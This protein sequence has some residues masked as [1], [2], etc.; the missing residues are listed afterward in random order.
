MELSWS[1]AQY[2][3]L[4][5][6]VP[7]TWFLVKYLVSVTNV[8]NR[9]IFV[10]MEATEFEINRFLPAESRG[11]TENVRS[12]N[13]E[14]SERKIFHT[15]KPKAFA[16]QTPKTFKSFYSNLAGNLLEKLP[17]PPN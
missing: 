7:D 13:S 9:L 11:S 16:T 12:K 4:T 15:T 10:E 3:T 2:L 17:K 6:T 5:S 8:K 14:I 1:Q